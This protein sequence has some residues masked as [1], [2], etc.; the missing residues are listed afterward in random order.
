[1][2]STLCEVHNRLF[3]SLPHLSALALQAPHTFFLP[4][5]YTNRQYDISM[6][7]AFNLNKLRNNATSPINS[8]FTI[9][10]EY[11]PKYPNRT[12]RKWGRKGCASQQTPATGF[13]FVQGPSNVRSEDQKSDRPQT[14][15]VCFNKHTMQSRHRNESR[16]PNK[17]YAQAA[18]HNRTAVK[19]SCTYKVPPMQ[20][21]MNERLHIKRK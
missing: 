3:R 6:Q 16:N 8:L 13:L 1:V 20:L 15:N 17:E 7:L 5:F 12:R 10:K 19:L 18:L 4:L 2:P 9:K 21:L 14:R 11:N